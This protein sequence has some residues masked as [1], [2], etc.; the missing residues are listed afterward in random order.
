MLQSMEPQRTGHDCAATKQPS[1]EKLC[2]HS[3][4]QESWILGS[5]LLQDSYGQVHT[6]GF[7]MGNQQGHPVEH[8]EL[9]SMFCGSLDGGKDGYSYMCG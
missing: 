2:S 3:D 8:R 7:K 6:A 4:W 1:V 5:N 9:C